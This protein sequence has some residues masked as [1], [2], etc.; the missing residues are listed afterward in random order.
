MLLRIMKAVDKDATPAVPEE[1]EAAAGSAAASRKKKH[2][3]T[4][5]SD[6]ALYERRTSYEFARGSGL[7][8]HLPPKETPEEQVKDA[9]VYDFSAWCAFMGAPIPTFPGTAVSRCRS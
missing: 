5:P 4:K 8:A 7:S 3:A 9:S 2:L 6:L 1:E